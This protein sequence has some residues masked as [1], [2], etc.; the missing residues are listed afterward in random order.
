MGLRRGGFDAEGLEEGLEL[1][2]G[3]DD[4]EGGEGDG[5]GGVHFWWC[6]R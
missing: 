4:K 2:E 6:G 1:F 3:G 5:V